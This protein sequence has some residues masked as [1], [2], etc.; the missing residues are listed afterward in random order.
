M[1]EKCCPGF[2]FGSEKRLAKNSFSFFFSFSL[3]LE[4]LELNLNPSRQLRKLVCDEM[5]EGCWLKKLLCFRAKK[6]VFQ[7]GKSF[8][9]TPPTRPFDD[10]CNHDRAEVLNRR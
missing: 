10:D 9:D 4:W 7:I 3:E 8:I 2:F 5:N 6:K 1:R